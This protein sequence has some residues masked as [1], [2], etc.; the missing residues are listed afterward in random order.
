MNVNTAEP[1]SIE[2]REPLADMDMGSA[3]GHSGVR[4]SG[5]LF[6]RP[7]LLT[8]LTL[9]ALGLAGVAQIPIWSGKE[10]EKYLCY[11][12][13]ALVAC[14]LKVRRPETSGEVSMNYLFVLL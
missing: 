12:V 9:A 10:P 6:S 8:I 4:L 7:V 11:V 14:G 1:N 13:A 3:R 5:A 2:A